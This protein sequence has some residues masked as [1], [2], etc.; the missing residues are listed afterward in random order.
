M[1]GIAALAVEFGFGM[2]SF[3]S[4][5][6]VGSFGP[7]THAGESESA[8]IRR[9]HFAWSV[10]RGNIVPLSRAATARDCKARHVIARHVWPKHVQPQH[11]NSSHVNSTC[12]QGTCGQDTCSQGTCNQGTCSQVSRTQVTCCQDTGEVSCITITRPSPP[13]KSPQPH[14]RSIYTPLRTCCVLYFY[15]LLGANFKPI[16]SDS[17][18]DSDTY[19]PS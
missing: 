8:S 3:I 10:A 13:R 4:F 19:Y 6:L 14:H 15:S 5:L 17:N 1:L 2:R 18:S 16:C 11:G 7:C 9:R 12:R